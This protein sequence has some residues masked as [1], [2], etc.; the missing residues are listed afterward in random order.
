MRKPYSERM[1]HSAEM[2]ALRKKADAQ[3]AKYRAIVLE[4]EGGKCKV[5][6]IRETLV[7]DHVVPISRG[8]G[9]GPDNMQV[10]CQK[11][12]TLK[13]HDDHRTF[14]LKNFIYRLLGGESER[15]SL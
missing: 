5:C 15:A 3:V 14:M 6:G 7:I 12:N 8:G 11:H 9:L 13:R 1:Q 10:L 2:K 4:R